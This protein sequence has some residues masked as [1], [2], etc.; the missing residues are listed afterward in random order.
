M[1]KQISRFIRPCTIVL[2]ALL[3][4]T[5]AYCGPQ[6]YAAG[7]TA[8]EWNNKAIAS[9]NAHKWDQAVYG[10][11]KA[12]ALNQSD[13]IVARNLLTGYL[14]LANHLSEKKRF[15]DALRWANKAKKLK[16]T[17]SVQK[18]ISVIHANHAVYLAGVGRW[19]AAIR[20]A[21][22]ALKF[23]MQNKTN[24]KNLSNI[25]YGY[26]QTLDDTKRL[27]AAKNAIIYNP[28]S[29][30]NWALAGYAFY[31][32]DNLKQAVTHFEKALELSPAYPGLKA[33]LNKA[34]KD[35]KIEK[36]YQKTETRW[37]TV[38][39]SGYENTGLARDV[40]TVLDRAHYELKTKMGMFSD[41][42]I[43]V[44]IYTGDDYKT[45]SG[46]P[47][48]SSGVY[49]GKIRI[50]EGTIT[51]DRSVL[52]N[53]L[54]HEYTHAV[55]HERTKRAVPT[56]WNEGLAQHA[57]PSRKWN[58]SLKR[59]LTRSMT[60]GAWI[61]L[62]RLDRSFVSIVNHDEAEQAYLESYSLIQFL[63]SR[64]GAY[65]FVDVMNRISNGQKFD[66]VF[67][68]IYRMRI[69]ELDREWKRFL[70]S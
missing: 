5:A 59:K 70:K 1:Q 31:N 11:E 17:S 26:A 21:G 18:T 56:W 46:G 52:E 62:S 58:R 45:A 19:K 47:D 36:D 2:T 10:F 13:T 25:Y 28:Q 7:Y 60:T 54:Y 14:N 69:P 6:A 55:I 24:R 51:D 43:V 37:F 20:V 29:A 61:P 39:F 27:D 32:S 53:V 49:D 63:K 15:N 40:I 16:N 67:Y 35:L 48:W 33:L 8:H 68:T 42:K 57:E 41:K 65:S 22:L 44:V 38:K 50:K 66:D 30:S 9:S 3:L 34:K 12:Y 23:D 64:Y 4:G